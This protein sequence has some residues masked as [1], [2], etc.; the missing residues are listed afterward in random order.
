VA[1]PG[2]DLSDI[3]LNVGDDADGATQDGGSTNPPDPR[4]PENDY[5]GERRYE[6]LRSC[7]RRCAPSGVMIV[8]IFFAALAL[9]FAMRV[10]W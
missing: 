1:R 10:A 4:W 9:S 7:G 8:G 2:V 3:H 6:V 5:R